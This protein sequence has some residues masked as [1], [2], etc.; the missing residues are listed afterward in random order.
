MIDCA[1]AVKELWDYIEE[2]LEG[3]DRAQ[4]AA[5]LALCRRCC[6]ELEFAEEL[7]AFMRRRPDVVLPTDVSARLLTTLDRLGAQEQA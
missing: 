7:R 1:R 2:R 4:V 5:H 6:G 3:A